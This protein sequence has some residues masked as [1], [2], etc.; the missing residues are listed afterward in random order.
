MDPLPH[1]DAPPE[2]GF[3]EGSGVSVKL[4][5]QRSNSGPSDEALVKQAQ[6]GSRA[7]REAIYRR[8]APRLLNLATQLLQSREG[9]ED[10]LHDAFLAAFKT[11]SRMREP[12]KLRNW[13]SQIVVNKARSVLRRERLRRH[14]GLTSQAPPEQDVPSPLR[15]LDSA[16]ARHDLNSMLNQLSAE[17]RLVWWLQRVERYT[18]NEVAQLTQSSVDK[19]KKRLAAADKKLSS[20]RRNEESSAFGSAQ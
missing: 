16:L 10:V 3:D 1:T 14:L 11:L 6:A 7:A 15:D 20:N 12:S 17:A 5:A 4:D 13:L 2:S 19:V 18:V 8:Y 9:G